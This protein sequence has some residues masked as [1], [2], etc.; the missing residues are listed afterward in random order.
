MRDF[1]YRNAWPIVLGSCLV[2]VLSAWWYFRPAPVVPGE[3]VIAKPAPEVAHVDTKPV[4]IK[5]PV[6]VYKGGAALK[7][8]L[9]LPAAA[10]QDDNVE[11]L[12]SSKV[13]ADEH[14]HTITTTIDK[15][16]GEAV[17]YD[18]ADP[19][20]WLAFDYRGEVGVYVGEKATPRGFEPAL[21]VEAKQGLFQVKAVHVGAVASVDAPLSGGDAD[22]FI[23]VGAWYRW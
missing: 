18:R 6:N 22:A 15:E 8:G 13:P 7:N 10:V 3:T 23:G 4:E 19:L 16:T 11:V 9:K 14:T 20:P 21:R 5:K 17:T 12:T 2:I 1:I